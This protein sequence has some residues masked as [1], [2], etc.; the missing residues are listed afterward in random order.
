VILIQ[1]IQL[2]VIL[3]TQEI[4]IN[5]VDPVANEFYLDTL[6]IKEIFATTQFFIVDLFPGVTSATPVFATI[7][8]PS[9]TVANT[10]FEV[11]VSG[12]SGQSGIL[13]IIIDGG[14][15]RLT[16][17]VTINNV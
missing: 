4:I 12:S 14:K 15:K 7:D 8:N 17:P 3:G 13:T 2:H 9:I 6:T 11:S 5:A 16:I 10:G 1:G